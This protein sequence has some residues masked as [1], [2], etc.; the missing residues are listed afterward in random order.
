MRRLSTIFL[1]CAAPLAMVPLAFAQTQ[2]P[3][4]REPA[5]KLQPAAA[6]SPQVRVLQTPAKID[7]AK[8]ASI[9]KLLEVTRMRESFQQVMAGMTNN[10]RPIVNSML[11]PGEY[12]EKLVDLFFERF[13]SKLKVDE[14]AELVVP[15]YDKHFSREEIEGLIQFYQTPLGKKAISELPQV[16]IESQTES[17]KLGQKVGQDSMIEVLNEHP[18]LK[19][20][21]DDAAAAAPK[22]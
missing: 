14:L 3:Q 21:M 16:L 20:A 2:Q 11:P 4:K 10:M 15:I 5:A 6:A 19:K 17:M 22:N 1:C 13:Q 18:D 9:R 7:P 8:E 12:R